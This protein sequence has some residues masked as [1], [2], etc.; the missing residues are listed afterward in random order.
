MPPKKTKPKP[1]SIRTEADYPQNFDL[2]SLDENWR[3]EPKHLPRYYPTLEEQKLWWDAIGY[4]PTQAQLPLLTDPIRFKLIAGGERSGKSRTS[5]VFPVPRI[6]DI[7]L[8]WFVG[9]DYNHCRQEMDYFYDD[10]V[11][12]G[13][14]E[15]TS[16]PVS[17][18]QPCHVKLSTGTLVRTVT[19]ND[20]RRL[21]SQAP[22]IVI[23][24]EAAQTSEEAYKRCRGR[25]AEKR[26]DLILS[27][28]FED[29]LP[30][31]ADLYHA[32]QSPDAEGRSWSLPSWTNTFIYPEGENDPEILSM[33]GAY[34]EKYFSERIAG[35]P[36]LPRETVFPEFT[37]A[38]HTGH[39]P[40]NPDRPVELAIDP[41]Y[42]G[43]YAV[44]AIQWDNNFVYVVDEIY[45]KFKSTYDVIAEARQRPWWKNII[46]SRAGIIDIA[47][48]Q[49]HEGQSHLE[50]WAENER[51]G[52][53]G[54]SLRC[55]FIP[56][57]DGISR[58]RSFLKSPSTGKPRLLYNALTTPYSQKEYRL[59]KYPKDA[60]GK[61][62]IERPIDRDNHSIKAI[63]YWL[64][65]RYGYSN[66][67]RRGARKATW[68]TNRRGT[69][70]RGESYADK[71]WPRNS[72]SP[73]T[74]TVRL[75]QD[76]Q[77]AASGGTAQRRRAHQSRTPLRIRV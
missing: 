52:G 38:S 31:Y 37:V 61:P 58:L 77:V 74:E 73:G 22:D 51:Y 14:V 76:W 45:M 24:C 12:L 21:A 28:T 57:E 36:V 8:V 67:N 70:R 72:P 33:K 2:E 42:S 7:S 47:A 17:I 69:L 20:V 5:S 66:T 1:P 35:V 59:Y 62:I 55:R 63:T 11:A 9:P 40:F 29:S 48:K 13:A 39:H 3:P 56:I 34:D 16:M 65:N 15:R 43:A 53:G 4:R 71:Y 18:F 68:G 46:K 44:L 23:M 27:G 54:L 49:H 25:V 64:V 32:W 60:E 41:G 6:G 10:M 19:A 50:I 30:W 75:E 26:G